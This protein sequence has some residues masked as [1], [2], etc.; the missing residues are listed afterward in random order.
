MLV[1]SIIIALAASVIGGI[2]GIGG[3]VLMKPLFD[4]FGIASVS[5]ASFLSGVTVLSMSGYNTIKN[6]TDDRNAIELKT[7]VPLSIGAASGGIIGKLLF[8]S[9]KKSL[10][11]ADAIG[12]IQAVILGVLTLGTIIYTVCKGH[13]KT[14]HIQNRFLILGMGLLLGVL[15]SFLGIGGGPFN[16]PFLLYFFTLDSKTAAQN[17]LFI[18]LFSQLF[19]LLYSIISKSIP[20]FDTAVLI[21]MIIAGIAGGAIGKNICKRINNRTV[22]KLFVGLLAVIC[23]ICVINFKK[24]VG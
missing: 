19:S 16:I 21:A 7:M 2:C 5:T 23:F 10:P 20:P 8:E 12:A 3:G 24:F 18:I 17:S 15:S 6:L 22:D 13:I 1:L 9:A 14:K 4:L 11:N